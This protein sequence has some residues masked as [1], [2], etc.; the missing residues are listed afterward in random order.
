MPPLHG[1]RPSPPH[2]V[3]FCHHWQ[4]PATEARQVTSAL[5][6]SACPPAPVPVP[7]P[8]RRFPITHGIAGPL[9]CAATPS[10]AG[11][12]GWPCLLGS[13]DAQPRGVR[14]AACGSNAQLC[15]PP[16][17]TYDPSLSAYQQFC[18]ILSL[19][20]DEVASGGRNILA[21]THAGVLYGPLSTASQRQDDD[22][23]KM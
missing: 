19:E 5:S 15:P 17:P 22:H 13:H 4:C 21:T 3:R 7:P 10:A 14:S 11:L 23:S 6:P 1:P 20:G 9:H 8:A 18:S 16:N 12:P 2:R